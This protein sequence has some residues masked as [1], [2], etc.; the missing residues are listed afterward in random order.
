M[1]TRGLLKNYTGMVFL[2]WWR[3]TDVYEES[4]KKFLKYCHEVFFNNSVIRAHIFM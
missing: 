1:K 4:Y 2:K 3:S